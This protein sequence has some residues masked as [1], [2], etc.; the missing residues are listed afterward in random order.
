M[1][2]GSSNSIVGGVLMAYGSWLNYISCKPCPFVPF[3]AF[4]PYVLLVPSI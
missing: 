4:V 1:N 2:R 3:V